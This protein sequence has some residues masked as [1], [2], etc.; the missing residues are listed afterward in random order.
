MKAGTS[1]KQ[2][3]ELTSVFSLFNSTTERLTQAYSKLEDDVVRINNEL[4]AKNEALRQKIDEV[5]HVR[6]YLENIL[7]SMSTAV[8]ALDLQHRVTL[9]N[10]CAEHILGCTREMIISKHIAHIL[11]F[12]AAQ[13]KEI[14][15][16]CVQN[17]NS[18]EKETVVVTPANEKIT[19]GIAMSA[20][21]NRHDQ[22]T[23]YL[24]LFRDLRE[25]KGLQEKVRRADRLASIGEMAARVAHEIRNPLGGIE[26]FASLLVRELE[27]DTS[28]QQLAHYILQGA[29]SVNH[30]ITNLLDYARPI[31]LKKEL[32]SVREA[33]FDVFGNITAVKQD[34][35]ADIIMPN[36]SHDVQVFGDRIM[37]QQAIWN[38][39]VNGIDAMR[40]AGAPMILRV[41]YQTVFIRKRSLSHETLLYF[42]HSLNACNENI[43][44]YA[45]DR[46]ELDLSCWSSISISDGGQGISKELF[47]KVFFPFFTTKE[48]G[49]GLGLSTV[50]KIV[51]E[52]NGKIGVRSEQ[53]KGTCFTLFFPCP[54]E[55]RRVPHEH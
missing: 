41:D 37:I 12:E 49:S 47:E 6:S 29:Q 15:E 20:I 30:I 17:S 19:V 39:L 53:G 36:D 2:L 1:I 21:R 7:Q 22:T 38:I 5:N 3:E 43:V 27:S 42:E 44:T 8:I 11:V 16:L 9:I 48:N 14:F 28:K 33:V 55:Q 52:H 50:Y 46:N 40:S 45:P 54:Q 26:G 25:L 32:F 51:E 10:R 23:G 4:D 31:H 35:P 13:W 34:T 18:D 24:V